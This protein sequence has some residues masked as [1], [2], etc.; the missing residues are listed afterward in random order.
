VI[1]NIVAKYLTEA[2]VKNAS[3]H[4]LRH[5]FTTHHVAKGTNLKTVQEALEHSSLST[6][7]I[8]V[9]LAE[10]AMKKDLQNNAL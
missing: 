9:S 4:V 8:Y 10:D 5:S 1:G 7:S 6:A 3:V 2:G